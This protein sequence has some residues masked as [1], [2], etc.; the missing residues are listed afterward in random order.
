MN[1]LSSSFRPGLNVGQRTFLNFAFTS[2]SSF[3]L[4]LRSISI[5]CGGESLDVLSVSIRMPSPLSIIQSAVVLLSFRVFDFPLM[6][7]PS[8]VSIVF[9]SNTINVFCSP[10]ILLR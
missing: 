4:N 3:V 9:A 8:S 6:I 7:L 1:R 10:I 5:T 2:F